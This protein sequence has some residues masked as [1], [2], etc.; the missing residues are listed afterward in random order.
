MNTSQGSVLFEDVSVDFTR[1]EWRLLDPAQRLLCRDVMLE[2]YGHLASLGPE[3]SATLPSP[4]SFPTTGRCV[5]KAE[6]IF[7][8]EQGEEPWVPRRELPSQSPP[9]EE[10]ETVREQGRGRE[11]GRHRI[12]SRLQAVSTEP[13]ARL[14]P[15]VKSDAE[16]TEPPRRP[17]KLESLVFMFGLQSAFRDM[18]QGSNS[19]R[20]SSDSSPEVFSLDVR[21]SFRP[22]GALC[23]ISNPPEEQKNTTTNISGC[24][25]GY[26]F[27]TLACHLSLSLLLYVDAHFFFF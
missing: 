17:W 21:V 24:T 3:P 26:D 22:E 2:N 1:K 18:P 10:R 15:E 25:P 20:P 13:D 8:L 12:Q 6:L 23:Q 5:T 11:R 7:K 14:E 9:G 16:P 27:A 19:D 4:M